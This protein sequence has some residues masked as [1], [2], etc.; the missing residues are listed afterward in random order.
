MWLYSKNFNVPSL[1]IQTSTFKGRLFPLPGLAQLTVIIFLV[2]KEWVID[3][4]AWC[5]AGSRAYTLGCYYHS[6]IKIY[7]FKISY[8]SVFTGS[9]PSP[10]SIHMINSSTI[11]W[12]APYYAM[13]RDSNFMHVDPHITQYTTTASKGSFS[14]QVY[15][16]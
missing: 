1:S 16:L 8:N 9:L 3:I 15:L 7:P 2:I 5:M 11:Q 4:I 10:E 13:N 14:I 6:S 12:N